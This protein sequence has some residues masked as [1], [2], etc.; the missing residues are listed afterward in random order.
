MV[1]KICHITSGNREQKTEAASTIE[2]RKSAIGNP[3]PQRSTLNAFTLI[4]LLVVIAI[5]S[6]LAAILFPVFAQARETARQASCAG[7]MK[8]IGYAMRMYCQDYDEFWVPAYSQGPGPNGSNIQPWIGFD[9]NNVVSSS[10]IGGDMTQPATREPHPGLLDPYIK[11]AQIKKC[12]D[13]PGSW[14]MALAL[15]IF[16]VYLDL[17]YY[18]ANPAAKGNEFGPAY[19]SSQTDPITEEE[20]PLGAHDSEIDQ[21]STTLVAWEHQNPAPECNFL[22]SPDWLNS[23]PEGPYRD[24]FHL[25]H[26][27]GATC[28]WCDS[29]VKHVIYDALKRPWFSC[30]K[31]IY[32][33]G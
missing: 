32:P 2:N 31:D 3:T 33:G 12:P 21:P 14:Q 15:N 1:Y 9:N 26:R 4:E 29:H 22:Q 5:I 23:P 27:N 6:I 7:N 18:A 8:Q 16:N 28:L 19:R 13:V 10:P 20:M 11:N 30:R 17:D 25:L 24:H